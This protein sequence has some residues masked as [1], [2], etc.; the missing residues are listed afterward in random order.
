MVFRIQLETVER[1]IAFYNN[2]IYQLSS[3][4]DLALL[5]DLA[6]LAHM[7]LPLLGEGE[8]FYEGKKVASSVVMKYFEWQPIVLNLK[9]T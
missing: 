5:G 2:D 9:K 3:R 7:S 8:V 1:L 4:R 6:P